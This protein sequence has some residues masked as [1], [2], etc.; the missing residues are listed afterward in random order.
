MKFKVGQEVKIIKNTYHHCFQMGTI[1][2]LVSLSDDKGIFKAQYLDGHDFWYV[3][4]E[5]IEEVKQPQTLVIYPK[6]RD[7]IATIKEGKQVIK[8]AKA[9]CCPTDTYDFNIGARLAF[10][11][12][13]GEETIL[14]IN[15]NEPCAPKSSIRI[16]KQD[17]YAVGDKVRLV[18]ERPH[19]WN[20]QGE[21]DKYLGEIVVIT[22]V[23]C[24]RIGFQGMGGW[25]INFDSIEGKVIESTVNVSTARTIP[26]LPYEPLVKQQPKPAVKEEPLAVKK[27]KRPAKVGDKIKITKLYAHIH[28]TPSIN[29]GDIHTITRIFHDVIYTDK[30]NAIRSMEE[31][32]ITEEAKPEI[33]RVNRKAEIGEYIEIVDGSG[34]IATKVGD[35]AKVTGIWKTESGVDYIT[36]KGVGGSGYHK[37]YIVLENY[38]EATR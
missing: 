13:M 8:S 20:S 6:G 9:T 31:Y 2:R 35:I 19:T 30:G 29:I 26:W 7:T 11:K 34:C 5:D 36:I 4:P 17:M 1:V 23:L 38:K 32:I 12:L 28:H 15:P 16:V 21:M 3:K 22:A 25:S 24:G 27:V 14:A 33:K 37:R 18:S 10:S